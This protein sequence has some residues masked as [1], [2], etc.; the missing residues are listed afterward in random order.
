M[1]QSTSRDREEAGNRPRSARGSRSLAVAARTV[2][3]NVLA[4]IAFLFWLASQATAQEPPIV[5]Q[6][7]SFSGIVGQVRIA[8]ALSA[9]EV[10]VEEPVVLTATISGTV[11]EPYLPTLKMLNLFPTS[12]DDD[13]FIEPISETP[14]QNEWRFVYKLRPKSTGVEFV[15]SLRL[16]F[17]SPQRRAYQTAIAPALPLKVIEKKPRVAS[18]PT[19]PKVELPAWWHEPI[20]EPWRL[21]A[22]VL[23][24]LVAIFVAPPAVFYVVYRLAQR[25]ELRTPKRGASVVGAA[26][27]SALSEAVDST[28]IAKQ[29]A[30]YFQ[31]RWHWTVEEPTGPEIVR[32]LKR[33]G[34]SKTHQ[35]AWAEFWREC[36][37]GRFSGPSASAGS[38]GKQA[39]RLILSLEEAAT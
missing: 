33:S 37:E 8:S 27:A 16:V 23:P 32:W 22:G 2:R 21:P 6:P 9:A 26:A 18:S 35:Q 38:L 14:S 4:P 1:N 39:G 20:E 5:G 28:E 12:I 17:Y 36:D 24:L 11:V 3:L 25:R 29:I 15:P 19:Q 10:E 30:R 7:P 13:F 34:F 31:S